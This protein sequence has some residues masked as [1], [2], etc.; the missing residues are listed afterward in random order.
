MEEQNAGV[1]YATSQGVNVEELHDRICRAI[2]GE[3]VP[4]LSVAELKVLKACI[5][6]ACEF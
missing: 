4:H 3:D 6:V 1:E 5:E 2:N